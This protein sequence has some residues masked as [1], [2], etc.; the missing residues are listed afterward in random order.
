MVSVEDAEPLE[1][2]ATLV[3]LRETVG[4]PG[5]T[6]ALSATVPLKPLR[7]VNV[8]VADVDDPCATV[9]IV[10]FVDALKSG[11]ALM[12]EWTTMLPIMCCRCIEQ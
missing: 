1:G 6:V 10:G 11:P 12:L 7:L 4:P 9:S 3:K 8:R 5:E 2:N